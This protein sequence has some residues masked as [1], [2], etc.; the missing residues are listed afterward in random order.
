MRDRR[1][2]HSVSLQAPI[3]LVRG[4]GV[5]GPPGPRFDHKPVGDDHGRAGE[6]DLEVLCVSPTAKAR[7]AMK[8]RIAGERSPWASGEAKPRS[9]N[10]RYVPVVQSDRTPR[11]ERGDLGS[12]PN[13]D[14]IAHPQVP[15]RMPQSSDGVP[16]DALDRTVRRRA[17]DSAPGCGRGRP[18]PS[19]RII[20]SGRA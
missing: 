8:K 19:Q 16:P 18:A 11:Y 1:E 5:A 20:G 15:A 14:T 3:R 2:T 6:E 9:A 12:S 4:A 10:A 17:R 13:G 7:G